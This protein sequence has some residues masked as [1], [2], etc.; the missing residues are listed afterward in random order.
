MS[1]EEEYRKYYKYISKNLQSKEYGLE[2][3]VGNEKFI[4]FHSPETLGIKFDISD[5]IKAVGNFKQ[6]NQTLLLGKK[7][8]KNATGQLIAT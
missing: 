1:I 6:A 4:G 2:C 7:Y 5:H 3:S 8:E